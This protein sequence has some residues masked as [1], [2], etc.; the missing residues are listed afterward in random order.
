MTQKLPK[1]VLQKLRQANLLHDCGKLFALEARDFA[2]GDF[3]EE[4]RLLGI[5]RLLKSRAYKIY[6]ILVP[7]IGMKK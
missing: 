6:R 7:W 3:Q 2:G 4:T 1:P 5:S